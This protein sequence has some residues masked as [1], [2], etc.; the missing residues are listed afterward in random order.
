[1]YEG[2]R[3]DRE[4]DLEGKTRENILKWGKE[5]RGDHI[6]REREGENLQQGESAINHSRQA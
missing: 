2:R 1:L 3:V 4:N 6:R 5:I